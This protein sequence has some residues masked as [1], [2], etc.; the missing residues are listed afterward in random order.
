MFDKPHGDARQHAPATQRNAS[1]IIDVLK[2]VLP[3][4][5]H[6]LEIASGSGEH[7]IAFAKAMP[8]LTWQPSDPF[9]ESRTSID[10]WAKQVTPSRIDPALDLDMTRSDW[11]DQLPKPVN[12]VLSINMIHIAPWEACMGLMQGAGQ[13]LDKGEILYTYGPYRK[14]GLQTS[15]SNQI[16]EVWLK[17]KSEEY[18]IRDMAIVAKEAKKHGL[19]LEQEIE[20]PANNFSLIFKKV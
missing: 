15:E 19:I 3:Q 13:L 11:S 20:M 7:I 17:G 2:D 9:G 1:F 8:A 5:G 6:V 18:G 12:A 14:N 4:T 16:F 10:A